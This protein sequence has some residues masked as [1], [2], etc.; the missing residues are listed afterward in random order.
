M[1]LLFLESAK[2]PLLSGDHRGVHDDS[3]SSSKFPI[4]LWD[5]TVDVV[6]VGFGGAGASAAVEAAGSGASV[7]VADRFSGGGSTEKSGGVAYFGGGT[8]LQKEAGISDSPGEMFNYLRMETR[9]A[10]GESTLRAFCESS[11]DNLEWMRS[12]GVPFHPRGIALNTPHPPDDGTLYYSGNELSYPYSDSARPAPRGHKAAGK[13]LTGK[14]MFNPMRRAA[15]KRGVKILDRT[16]VRRLVADS[17]GRV[18]GVE[19]RTLS[20]NPVTHLVHRVFY[21]IINNAGAISREVTETFHRY[22]SRLEA[23]KGKKFYIRARG[24]VI[25]ATGGFAFN[26]GMM[27]VHSPRFSGRGMRLGTAGDTGSGILLG[28]SAGGKTE[29][30]DSVAA[31]CSISPPSAMVRGLLVGADGR[32]ICSEEL[33]GAVIGERIAGKPDGRGFLILD[34]DI[35]REVRRRLFKER[36]GRFQRLSWLIRI[37][38]HRR[39]AE[40]ISGL[41]FHCGIYPITLAET[42]EDFNA[43]VAAG[44]DSEGKAAYRLEQVKNPPYHAIDIDLAGFPSPAPHFTLGGLVVDGVTARVVRYDGAHIEGLYASGRTAVGVSSDS[45][46][47]GLSIADAV[48]SGR[49]AGRQA[50]RRAKEKEKKEKTGAGGPALVLDFDF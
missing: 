42:V 29:K 49:N 50:A 41:A 44:A 36:M 46:V 40:T 6:V 15:E 9:D 47:G 8:E 1:K 12:L 11:T 27:R 31:L 35:F 2:P 17:R 25:L 16:E 24:G 33:H 19:I 37:L 5:E 18:I 23:R 4:R 43:G 30:M 26:P 21:S 48:F 22:L 20:S 45:Y 39:K 13:G 7:L 38:F 10:V 34:S 32:R 28:R 14:K 3:R